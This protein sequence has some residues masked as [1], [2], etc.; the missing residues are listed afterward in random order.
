MS[1]VGHVAAITRYP[2]KSLGGEDL[3][4]TDL[5]PLGIAD[6][7]RWA[8]RD[9][10]TGKIISAKLP[11]V[12]RT[13]LTWSARLDHNNMPIIT[14][15][16]VQ[17]S[18]DS[19]AAVTAIEA[20]AGEV[21]GRRVKL[22]AAGTADEVYE[23]YWPEIEGLAMS[24]LST[25]LPIA[26]STG[27]GTFVD[28][29]ALHLVTTASLTHLAELAPHS[30]INVNRF[31]PSMVIDT[32]KLSAGFFEN[33]WTDRRAKLGA[34]TL[35]FGLKSPRCVMTTLAQPGLEDDPQVL[36]TIAAHNRHDFSG[37]GNFAC[38]GIYAEVIE[39]GPV[40]VGDALELL[41]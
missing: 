40:S 2:V 14:L 3:L 8:L 11:S 24:D 22:E 7:R 20:R 25:D 6:D 28:L 1:I 34:A 27:K 13:L 15:G 33:G 38:L 39:P 16:G 9:L 35:Q 18:T 36:Q 21:L 12:G 41:S 5:G 19:A 17:F 32:G 30:T 29:A 23:S 26:M 4:S 37:F 31:R 10:D